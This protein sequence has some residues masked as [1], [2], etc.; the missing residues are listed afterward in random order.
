M[1]ES[2]FGQL[3]ESKHFGFNRNAKFDFDFDFSNL[4]Y[5]V[6][7]LYLLFLYVNFN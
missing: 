4:A 3:I 5:I 2:S 1:G 7:S 6:Y